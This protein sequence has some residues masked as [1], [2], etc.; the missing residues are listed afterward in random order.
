[1]AK[2]IVLFILAQ[3]VAHAE[4]RA[5]SLIAAGSCPSTDALRGAVRQAMPELEFVD[6][7]LAKS[8]IVV[9]DQGEQYRVRTPNGAR[10]FTDAARR[11]DDRAKSAAVV[12]GLSLEVASSASTT[13]VAPSPSPPPRVISPPAVRVLPNVTPAS[14]YPLSSINRP[15][16]LPPRMA[17]IDIGLQ[18]SDI[19]GSGDSSGTSDNTGETLT[20]SFDVGIGHR[21]QTGL[22]L[23]VPIHPL[24]N[25]GALVGNLQ[26]AINRFANLRLDLGYLRMVGQISLDH[27]PP[28]AFLKN[29]SGSIFSNDSFVV[30]FGVPLKWKFHSMLALVSGSSRSRDFAQS[31]SYQ[32]QGGVF[33]TGQW[34]TSIYYLEPASSSD[35]VA[36]GV[37]ARSY[38]LVL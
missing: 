33:P 11:C 38:Y 14:V 28:G 32:Y 7:D 10:V 3:S 9:E 29:G 15:L 23:A 1:M 2:T 5:V 21:L 18:L 19:A 6:A 30:G 12:I 34:L 13:N 4:P 36:F 8:V 16:I 25:F 35:L 22:S 37:F 17:L 20:A 26:F 24:A 31:Q 27:A